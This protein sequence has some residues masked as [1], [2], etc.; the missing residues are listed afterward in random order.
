HTQQIENITSGPEQPLKQEQAEVPDAEDLDPLLTENASFADS[1]L[2]ESENTGLLVEES[3][4]TVLEKEQEEF[5]EN[6]ESNG[7]EQ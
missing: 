4:S 5:T 6:A 3:D 1:L 2:K 7:L